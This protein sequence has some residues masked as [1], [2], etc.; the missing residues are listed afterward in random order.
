MERKINLMDE[1]LN[2]I[3]IKNLVENYKLCFY[4]L[5]IETSR[6][7]T[8]TTIEKFYFN[9]KLTPLKAIWLFKLMYEKEKLKIP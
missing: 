5:L 6:Y 1:K 2:K 9:S 3:G 8:Q 4:K 7:K